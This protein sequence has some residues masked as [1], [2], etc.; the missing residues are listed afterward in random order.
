MLLTYIFRQ[1]FRYL[2]TKT[3]KRITKDKSDKTSEEKFTVCSTRVKN[4][5]INVK[6]VK[7][8]SK[9]ANI[10]KNALIVK[11]E[12]PD[13]IQDPL[14]I[15][16]ENKIF[17]E[18]IKTEEKLPNEIKIK[19]E[20]I[21][22]EDDNKNLENVE[23]DKKLKWEPPH[24]EEVLKNLREMRKDQEAPVD[25]MGCHKCMDEEAPA[26]V[27][28]YIEISIIYILVHTLE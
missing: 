20:H 13:Y 11:S 16:K 23:T 21:K 18:Q 6:N 9:K 7:T 10:S 27:S 2:K 24:W 17:K 22:V 25:S 26:V 8:N 14:L 19:R 15:H 4:E 28:T 12:K 3:M 5:E 1:N